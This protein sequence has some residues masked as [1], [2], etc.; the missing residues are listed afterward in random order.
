[1]KL[2]LEYHEICIYMFQLDHLLWHVVHSFSPF[3][4]PPFPKFRVSF[5]PAPRPTSSSRTLARGFSSAPFSKS[6][7]ARPL[8][9]TPGAGPNSTEH[10]E[11]L[12]KNMPGFTGSSSTFHHFWGDDRGWLSNLVPKNSRTG[13]LLWLSETSWS[14]RCQL[15][16]KNI[17]VLPP[18]SWLEHLKTPGN[19]GCN[20]P[21]VSQFS[22]VFEYVWI[23]RLVKFNCQ[24]WLANFVS[25][26]SI[27]FH[28]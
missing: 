10:V 24:W 20:Y 17:P 15:S 27:F 13:S 5:P 9:E 16:Q 26:E 14:I 18:S 23:V 4:Y 12:C 11:C 19:D 7:S 3:H 21:H 2:T 25:V 8:L 1:M 6:H 22:S 28:A